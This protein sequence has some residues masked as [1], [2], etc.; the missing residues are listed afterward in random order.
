MGRYAPAA[1][2]LPRPYR[3]LGERVGTDRQYGSRAD[4]RLRMG[5]VERK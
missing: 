3:A 4:A 2:R 5:T 1:K